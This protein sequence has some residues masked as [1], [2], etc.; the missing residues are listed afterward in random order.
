MAYGIWHMVWKKAHA[1]FI[2]IK[3]VTFDYFAS[4]K[5]LY[6]VCTKV[7]YYT[8]LLGVCGIMGYEAYGCFACAWRMTYAWQN[9]SHIQL[10]P[11]LKSYFGEHKYSIW[12][13]LVYSNYH[14]DISHTFGTI[15]V[16]RNLKRKTGWSLLEYS[17]RSLTGCLSKPYTYTL[18][19]LGNI[20]VCSHWIV[21]F[22]L[23]G[24]CLV[25]EEK[26]C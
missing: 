9:R 3:F 11:S 19:H 26:W 1:S 21:H 23:N 14:L 20:F 25:P 24:T 2:Y 15:H 7:G 16:W 13:R 5:F 12:G 18:F 6:I 10:C 17:L 8:P 4:N 22:F